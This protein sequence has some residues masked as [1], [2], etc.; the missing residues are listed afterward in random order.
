M[1]MQPKQSA[2]APARTDR[3]PARPEPSTL[4]AAG[5]ARLFVRRVGPGGA[6]EPAAVVA[7][8]GGPGLSHEL[9]ELLEPLARRERALICYDQRGTGRSTGRIDARDVLGQAVADLD[10]VVRAATNGGAR[11]AHLLGHG[12][13]GLIASMYAAAHPDQTS[14]LILVDSLPPTAA[15]LAAAW[16]RAEARVRSFQ[17]RGLVPADLPHGLDD[18]DPRAGDELLVA[19][20]P[21]CFVDP[22]HPSAR[23]LAGARFEPRVHRAAMSALSAYDMREA[24][25]R[26]RAP[27]LHVL[28]SVPFGAEMGAALADAMT[29]SPG[30]RLVLTDAGHLPW[31]ERPAAFFTA[32]EAFLAE[33]EVEPRP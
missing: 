33:I 27:A 9:M 15:A 10:L 8:S 7:I 24:V 18:L 20:L 28:A 13:G 16:A 29:A 5:D 19:L 30:R 21:A 1:T 2:S 32:V 17:A 25:A 4:P 23:T 22:S 26:V 14:S 12:W 3:L 31:L 6:G 11:A